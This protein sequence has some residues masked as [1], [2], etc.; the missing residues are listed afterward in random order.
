M[1]IIFC[2][3]LIAG[4]W[5]G[6]SWL[7]VIFGALHGLGLISNHLYRKLFEYKLNKY[8]AC[9]LTFN[10]INLTFVFFRSSS[11]EDSI[12]IIKGMLGMNGVE[13][14]NYFE[15]KIFIITV[16][17]VAIII[18]FAFKNTNYLIDKIKLDN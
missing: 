11:L 4:L 14:L 8:I 13:Y 18:S 9:F 2:V 16:L 10:Y 1:F 6:P 7:F 12:N 17:L 15:N 3:F 5:H